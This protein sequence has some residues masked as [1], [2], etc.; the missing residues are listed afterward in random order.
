MRI[1]LIGA[2]AFTRHCLDSMLAVGANVVGVAGPR[3]SA[4]TINSDYVDMPAEARIRGL[5][6]I[7]FDSVRAPETLDAV[8]ALKPDVVFVCGLS[9]LLPAELL[10]IPPLGVIGTHPSLLPHGRGRHPLIWT[11]VEGLK[12]GGLT[13]FR[14]D[15]GTDTGDIVW[16]QAF[17]VGDDDDAA[18]LYARIEALAAKAITELVPRFADGTVRYRPQDHTR[19]TVWR[20][21]TKEDGE[22]RWD[23]PSRTCHNLIRA[24]TRPY[25][26]AHTWL[27]DRLLRV[28]KA[29]PA[30]CLAVG[31]EAPGT[32]LSVDGGRLLVRTGDGALGILDWDWDQDWDQS[33]APEAGACLGR[34]LR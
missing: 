21:R 33:S 26:G 13:F 27:D 28:W 31:S 10:A 32:I 9:Q 8:A 2:V 12:E 20:R 22:I 14:I 3:P 16:Q 17:P 19:A 15:E 18:V 6:G 5:H 1:V 34:S 24:L 7:P 11:L 4:A 23:A 30:S 29:A 25:V